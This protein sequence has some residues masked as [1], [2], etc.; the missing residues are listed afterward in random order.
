VVLFVASGGYMISNLREFV[1]LFQTK[2][3]AAKKLGV[4]DAHLSMALKRNSK[5]FIEH[6]GKEVL[7]AKIQTTK[8]WG[9]IT[10]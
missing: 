4:S 7:S 6:D 9:T 8:Q 3:E 5:I 10:N 2:T 1:S